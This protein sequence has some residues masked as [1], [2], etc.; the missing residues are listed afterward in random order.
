MINQSYNAW[1]TTTATCRFC[2]RQYEI[3]LTEP[4]NATA[5]AMSYAVAAAVAGEMD[6]TGWMDGACPPCA[7][8]R[9][10][11]IIDLHR[12]DNGRGEEL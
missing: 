4:V 2:S 10:R 9:V 11:C 8:S 7:I 1:I 12:A 3:K 5:E 6:A